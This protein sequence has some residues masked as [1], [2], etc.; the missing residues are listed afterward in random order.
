[1]LNKKVNKLLSSA[2]EFKLK[3]IGRIKNELKLKLT[4]SKMIK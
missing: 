2:I 1:M 3:I 4:S